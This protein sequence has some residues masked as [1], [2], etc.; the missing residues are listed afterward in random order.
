MTTPGAGNATFLPAAAISLFL[1]S[2]YGG[3]VR[4]R[5]SVMRRHGKQPAINAALGVGRGGGQWRTVLRRSNEVS[6]TGHY[7]EP[8]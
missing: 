8:D 6:T 4:R 3:A 5:L 1:A 2:L 7:L